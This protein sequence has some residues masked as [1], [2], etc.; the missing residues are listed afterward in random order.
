MGLVWCLS[1]WWCMLVL[2]MQGWL[3]AELSVNDGI[4]GV[5]KNKLVMV[6][7]VQLKKSIFNDLRL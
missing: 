3:I 7:N 6:L 1:G 4:G 2:L 5:T